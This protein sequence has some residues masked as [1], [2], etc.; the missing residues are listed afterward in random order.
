MGLQSGFGGY[1]G[2]QEKAREAA[3]NQEKLATSAE[4]EQR[5]LAQEAAA[6]AAMD[7]YRKQQLGLEG[8]RLKETVRANVERENIDRAKMMQADTGGKVPE[9]T[10]A[11][12]L[13]PFEAVSQM[14]GGQMPMTARGTP[15]IDAVYK[16]YRTLP[17]VPEDIGDDFAS[18]KGVVDM[19]QQYLT[20]SRVRPKNTMPVGNSGM[21]APKKPAYTVED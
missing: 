13:A 6:A 3:L 2:G 9:V 1:M 16:I 21:T 20:G 18:K 10:L 15:D 8:S 7:Q 4:L 17:G 19:Y 5:K 11:S 14:F 12:G